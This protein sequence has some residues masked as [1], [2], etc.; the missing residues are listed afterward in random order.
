MLTW[1]L[2]ALRFR[3]SALRPLGPVRV[4]SP[5]WFIYELSEWEPPLAPNAVVEFSEESLQEH[6][7]DRLPQ[8]RPASFH[9]MYT[10]LLRRL[11]GPIIV[12]SSCGTFTITRTECNHVRVAARPLPE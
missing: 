6:L 2:H 1:F 11:K 7:A 8:Q 3:R 4:G 5:N 10:R 12:T 9:R